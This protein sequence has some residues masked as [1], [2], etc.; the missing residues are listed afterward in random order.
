MTR[1]SRLE[2]IWD[3]L[4]TPL[5]N[6]KRNLL[7]GLT[8]LGLVILAR[9]LGLFQGLE[10]KTLD[11]LLRLRPAEPQ[12]ERIL[13]V[14]LDEEDIQQIGTYPIPDGDLAQLLQTL[15]QA[16]PLTI[17]IDIYRDLPVPP[18]HQALTT[19]LATTANVI[20]IEKLLNDPVPI[21]PPAS[22]P[23]EQVGF[24]NLPIDGDGFI[25]RSLL[26][27]AT[28]TGD[29][30]FSLALR[31]AEQYLTAAGQPLGNGQRD[32]VAMRFGPTEL[33]RFQPNSGAYVGADAKGNQ[34]LLN[35]RSGVNPFR[36][37]SY[38]AVM[39][40]QVEPAWIRDRIVLIGVTSLSTKDLLNSAAVVAEN[41]GLVFG[42]E[43][44]AHATS[45]IVS[46]V[47]DQRPL[48]HVWPDAWEYLWIVLWGGAG[49]VLVRRLSTPS[50]YLLVIILAG[51]GLVGLSYTLLWQ[52][53][54][55]IPLVPTLLAFTINGLVLPGF[56][57]YD[58]TLRS[59]IE[60]RQRVIDQ[61]YDAIHNGPLQTLA[62]VL[63][64]SDDERTWGQTL[65]QLHRLNR[66]LRDIYNTLLKESLP[67]SHQLYLDG[68][69][70]LLDLQ[71]PLHEVLYQ[72][73]SQ[74]LERPFPHF[75]T[76]RVHIVKF[77]PM[78]TAR[79]S[80][81]DRRAL[82]RFLEEALC[83]V[84]KYA[85][86]AT[87]LAVTCLAQDGENWIR[88]QDNGQPA[89]ETPAPAID[90][91]LGGRG[92]QQAQQLAKRLGGQF[93]RSHPSPQGTCCELRW[94]VKRR[95]L[96]KQGV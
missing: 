75:K 13:I 12:D 43:L 85:Q 37:V 80:T 5:T 59:R 71:S 92:T 57:L 1:N 69:Q 21:L 70:A 93:L 95:W 38:R 48:L 46:A 2:A 17:G 28:E 11:T 94:P 53:G 16:Q 39:A 84:G 35:P 83:N 41:P 81:D 42:V 34:I 67:Q 60:E 3:Q 82:C 55:W 87:R 77:E 6:W 36:V 86:G 47:L 40:G 63:R 62:Q 24:V 26:G 29:Y 7:P 91:L 58:Q 88:V 90:P 74:T 76:I 20:G 19:T 45:Q 50:A 14:G 49:M 89:C 30:R 68:S 66:D 32:P 8:V 65:P 73:Y 18:G 56:Y 44:Q 78:E 10:W 23:P 31:L 4:R 52:A 33:V 54:W 64:Q 96:R 9:I 79:L 27:M 25:R 61:T 15:N 51:V 72:V 22:L